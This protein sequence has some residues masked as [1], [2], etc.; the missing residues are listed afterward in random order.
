MSIMSEMEGKFVNLFGEQ[1]PIISV[2]T[3][4]QAIEDGV[5][6]DVSPVAREEG[7]KHPVALTMRVV[8]EVII[9]PEDVADWQDDLGRLRDLLVCPRYAIGRSPDP[10]TEL[11]FN[12]D[13]MDDP[14]C[15]KTITLKAQCGPGDDLEPVI[16]V[17]FPDED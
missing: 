6:W 5:L 4:A 15:R 2:Y 13:V 17:M 3:R 10:T 12:M 7:F 11:L 9:P 14:K 1:I 8:S 16:T